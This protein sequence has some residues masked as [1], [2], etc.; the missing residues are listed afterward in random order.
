M[1]CTWDQFDLNAG[2]VNKSSFS[3]N[4]LWSVWVVAE[5][6]L[7]PMI[8]K[9]SKRALYPART[10]VTTRDNFLTKQP[11]SALPKRFSPNQG[12]ATFTTESSVSHIQ[13]FTILAE[14]T[15]VF[16]LAL[17]WRSRRLQWLWHEPNASGCRLLLLFLISW[18]RL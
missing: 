12:G 9:L 11:T 13:C 4:R 5:C 2:D 18:R 1:I 8:Y 6:K 16:K 15:L 17:E 7:G 10:V 14:N 3:A